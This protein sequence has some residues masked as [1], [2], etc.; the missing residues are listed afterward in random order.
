MIKSTFIDHKS[1]AIYV[2]V[3]STLATLSG[4]MLFAGDPHPYLIRHY[5][6]LDTGSTQ[7]Q[8]CIP[9][10]PTPTCSWVVSTY[11]TVASA[12]YTF[13]FEPEEGYVLGSIDMQQRWAAFRF[14]NVRGTQPTIANDN[15]ATGVQHIRCDADS[16]FASDSA[17][18]AVK[19]FTR[20]GP[21]LCTVS[22]D[23]RISQT[24]GTWFNISGSDNVSPS[25]DWNVYFNPG[26]LNGDDVPGDISISNNTTNTNTMAEYVPGVYKNVR[27]ES[28]GTQDTLKLFYDGEMIYS[29]VYLGEPITLFHIL[30]DNTAGSIMDID[31]LV[32]SCDGPLLL[33]ACCT[34]DGGCFPGLTFTECSELDYLAWRPEASCDVTTCDGDCCLPDL[35]CVE[36]VTLAECSAV[37]GEFRTTNICFLSG[38]GG[39]CCLGGATCDIEIRQSDCEDV[40][41]QFFGRG[42]E[43]ATVECCPDD[44]DQ[45]GVT[46]CQDVCPFVGGTGG[47]DSDGRPL[48]DLDA[49][50]FVDLRDTAIQQQNFTGP[51]NP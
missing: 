25:G 41:G 29:G 50:C 2:T 18:V 33:G 51:P 39:A 36:D 30:Y 23:I 7:F 16:S 14:D 22:M 9:S 26:D 37:N 5:E 8:L 13:G 48:G 17:L 38:C 4:A 44:P 31:N 43:C 49:N 6:A 19:A 11:E 28:D 32:V 46:G 47:V 20:V 24:G 34:M 40:G 12:V 15:P 35:S 10:E 1:R 3:V 42:T 27:V 45:D 21:G